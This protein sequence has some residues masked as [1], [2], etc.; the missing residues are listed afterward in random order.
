MRA[1]RLPPGAKAAVLIAGI[2]VLAG[3]YV[4]SIGPYWNI[5]PD[6]ATYV[7]WA[8]SLAAGRGWVSA[9]SSP[10]ATSVVFAA[11]LLLAPSGYAALNAAT[12]LLIFGALALA[13]E[14]FRRQG[15]PTLGLLAV[16]LSLASIHLYHASTQLL[17][18]PAYMVFSMAA[19]VLLS[20][21]G[22]Q[23]PQGDL[24]ARETRRGVG[25]E[26]LA[27]VLLLLTVMTRTIGITLP[28]AVLLVEGRALAARRRRPRPVRVVTA[29][30]AIVSVGAWE[31][32]AGRG[33]AAGWFR[34]FLLV[35]PWTPSAGSLSPDALLARIGDNLRLLPAPGSVLLNSW[36]SGH[37]SLDLLLRISGS[38]AVVAGLYLSLRERTTVGGIYLIL[39]LVIVAAH[40]LAGGD[41]DPRYL[42]PVTPLIFFYGLVAAR[43][44]F[45]V[46][47][48]LPLAAAAALYLVGYLGVGLKAMS[49]GVREAHSSPFGG[50]PIKRASNYDAERLALWLKSHSR[51]E[52][53]YAAGQRDMFDVISE[54][55]GYDV[56]PGLTSPREAFVAWLIQRQVRYLLVDRTGTTVGD[57]LLAVVRAYPHLFPVV[58]DLP[59]ASLYRVVPGLE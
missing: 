52:D 40:M 11:V 30:L 38:L 14:L 31:V 10:P 39:Y 27:G 37:P 33:Y 26:W 48:A 46:L 6:S 8:R 58:W 43:H 19:L 34:M 53:R 21:P 1:G 35:D 3:C 47:P 51:P 49:N 56:V 23:E 45:R 24:F 32:L 7:G 44:L 28:L 2:A 42:V 36:S 57:S 59:G 4:A 29:L 13:F 15:E 20:E 55:R 25:R 41:G 22:G 5:S 16:T 17:S 9:P 12:T 54:R 18:E 50:Y